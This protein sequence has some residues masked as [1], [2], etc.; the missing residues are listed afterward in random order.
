MKCIF[1]NL[2]WKFTEILCQLPMCQNKLMLW[3]VDL[4][5]MVCMKIMKG[6]RYLYISVY[7]TDVLFYTFKN[8]IRQKS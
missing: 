2:S 1:H 7:I 8:Y 3:F 5:G 6:Y 4:E